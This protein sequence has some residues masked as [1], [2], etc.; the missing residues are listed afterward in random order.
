MEKSIIY[1][2]PCSIVVFLLLLFSSA[3]VCA[4]N[5]ECRSFACNSSFCDPYIFGSILTKRMLNEL[6]SSKYTCI[7]AFNVYFLYT[8]GSFIR[9]S[10]FV[11][12]SVNR[13]F[14]LFSVCLCTFYAKYHKLCCITYHVE[15]KLYSLIFIPTF[16]P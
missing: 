7:N 8:E 5:L 12:V 2:Q 3:I 6:K 11:S 13:S 15:R 14:L 16:M 9:T 10:N 4:C 1:H